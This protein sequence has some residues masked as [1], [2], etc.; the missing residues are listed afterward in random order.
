MPPAGIRPVMITGDSRQTAC[1]VAK[2]LH[3]LTPGGELLTGEVLT[4]EV[5]T[6]EQ[7]NQMDEEE[8]A[9]ILPKVSVFARVTPAHKLRIVKALKAQGNIVAMTA[10]ASTTRPRSRRPTSASR[11]ARTAPTS[12]R[13]QA[14]SS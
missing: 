11:W 2:E 6:G 12:P 3:I 7:L 13:R 10:T 1:A 5:L 14:R 4:G 8:F 9:R